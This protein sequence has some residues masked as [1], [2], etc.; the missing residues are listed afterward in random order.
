MELTE[1]ETIQKY[2]KRCGHS[3][4]N[5]LLPYENDFTCFSCVYNVN[6]RKHEPL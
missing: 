2:G 3:N 6:K 5:T 1:D 4:Q